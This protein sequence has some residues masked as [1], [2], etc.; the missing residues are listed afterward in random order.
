MADAEAGGPDVDV[1]DDSEPAPR[2]AII[3]SDKKAGQ[4]VAGGAGAT[5]ADD[6]ILQK[7]IEVAQKKG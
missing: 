4:A 7:A 1:D 2:P 5:S 6:M 3:G